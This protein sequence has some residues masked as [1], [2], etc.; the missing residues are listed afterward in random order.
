MNEARFRLE[1]KVALIT[2]AA[3]GIGKAIAH[4]FAQ[5][6]AAICI[7]DVNQDG[8]SQTVEELKKHGGDA[9][10]YECNV[11]DSESCQAT[12]NAIQLDWKRIDILVNNAGVGLVGD[13][14][15]TKEEDFDR[16]MNVN[17][18]G[19][20]LMTQSVLPL[21]IEQGKGN[22]INM[23]SIASLI[24]VKD[25]FAYCASKGAVLMMTKCVALDYVKQG[26]RCNCICPAR[27]H[28][29]FVDEYLKK[30]YPGQE[31]EMFDNLSKYQPVGRMGKPEEVAYQ[32]LYL[33]SEESSFLTGAAL[34]L[35]GGVLM[36]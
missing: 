8:A 29:P 4:E 14:L 19:V 15:N 10:A 6:G 23:A 18:K 3:S 16:I 27:V 20:F 25:R 9:S 33:A 31:Q 7:A 32:A 30:N 26:I 24:A 22:I 12:V 11:T 21:M 35:D 17:A 34:P 13:L 5:A 2:G 36:G 28:T 1:N